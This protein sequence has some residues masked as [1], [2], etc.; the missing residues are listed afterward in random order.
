MKLG[1]SSIPEVWRSLVCQIPA[2]RESLSERANGACQDITVPQGPMIIG[3]V[4][5]IVVLISHCRVTRNLLDHRETVEVFIVN[6]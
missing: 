3:L 1:A 5:V 6:T 2:V 4:V